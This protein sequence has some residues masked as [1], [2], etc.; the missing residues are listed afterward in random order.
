MVRRASHSKIWDCI[1]YILAT[2]NVEEKLPGFP[3]MENAIS[4]K[5]IQWH[6]TIQ[7]G[8]QTHLVSQQKPMKLIQT[9][10]QMHLVSQQKPMKLSN[11]SHRCKIQTWNPHPQSCTECS[12][13]GIPSDN[14]S[15]FIADYSLKSFNP[16]I[17]WRFYHLRFWTGVK[18]W[19]T[20]A[21]CEVSYLIN[22]T[23]S[24]TKDFLQIYLFKNGLQSQKLH[25]FTED[26]TMFCRNH[27]SVAKS[28]D[29]IC[30]TSCSWLITHRILSLVDFALH[31]FLAY[32]APH[33]VLA[34]FCS[35]FCS[36]LFMHNILFLVVFATHP[37]LGFP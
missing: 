29:R 26:Q 23:R 4:T 13:R 37:E 19:H 14:S 18:A 3:T 2:P 24:W 17:P 21:T 33:P 5:I 34:W 30:I 7:T 20:T 27:L 32:Y 15:R 25:P 16:W 35:M 31:P 11:V 36:W 8:R 6:N 1:L 9:G 12:D 10:R 22:D 28:F